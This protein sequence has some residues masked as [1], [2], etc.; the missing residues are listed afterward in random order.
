MD[1]CQLSA[2]LQY[3]YIGRHYVTLLSVF[4]LSV[5]DHVA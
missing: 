1:F 2:L 4:S 5:L 3:C